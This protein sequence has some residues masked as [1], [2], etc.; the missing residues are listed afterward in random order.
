[1]PVTVDGERLVVPVSRLTSGSKQ[2]LAWQWYWIGGRTTAS[3][4]RAK[5]IQLEATLIEGRR[6]A[7]A[8]ALA[9]PYGADPAEAAA[10][11][12]DFMAARPDIAGVLRR[13]TMADGG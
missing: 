12:T 3:P 7:A 13:A 6:S 8:I 11:L 9:A 5:L 10:S 2:L 1:M 4:V